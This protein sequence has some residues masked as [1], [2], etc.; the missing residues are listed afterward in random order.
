MNRFSLKLFR[1]TNLLDPKVAT[2]LPGEH[3]T[4]IAGNLF[5]KHHSTNVIITL[6]SV[7][8]NPILNFTTSLS[9]I[10]TK[11]AGHNISMNEL[12][13]R[14]EAENNQILLNEDLSSN[15]FKYIVLLNSNNQQISKA[16]LNARGLNK[17]NSHMVLSGTNFGYYFGRDINTKKTFNVND[18]TIIFAS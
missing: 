18:G 2:V 3:F 8:P 12:N 16:D 17:I 11:L 6:V 13:R 5:Y 7:T 1:V 14:I 15:I 10:P 4:D 9:N